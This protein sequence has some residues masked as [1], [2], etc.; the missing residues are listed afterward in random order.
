MT[1][2]INSVVTAGLWVVTDLLAG[3]TW[4]VI[5]TLLGLTILWF[6]VVYVRGLFTRS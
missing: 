6:I 2:A 3:S 1:W 4:T 5:A